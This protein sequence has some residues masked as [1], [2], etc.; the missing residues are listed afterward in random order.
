MKNRHTVKF[1]QPPMKHSQG[2]GV[3]AAGLGSPGTLA[4]PARPGRGRQAEPTRQ[5]RGVKVLQGVRAAGRKEK[6]IQQVQ[7][8]E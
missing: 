8:H 2:P 7:M 6:E 1:P 4:S 3:V 5:E